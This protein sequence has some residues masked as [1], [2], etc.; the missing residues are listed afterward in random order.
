MLRKAVQQQCQAGTPRSFYT[1]TNGYPL[2]NEHF[3][4]E[5]EW[6]ITWRIWRWCAKER[7]FSVA[8][9]QITHGYLVGFS[10]SRGRHGREWPWRTGQAGGPMSRCRF[11]LLGSPINK[12]IQSWADSS[13]VDLMAL[14]SL[15]HLMAQWVKK[16]E[17][18][19]GQVNN[20][21]HQR[22]PR[23]GCVFCS[24]RAVSPQLKALECGRDFK[25]RHLKLGNRRIERNMLW[26]DFQ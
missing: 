23:I 14:W 22:C 18:L 13:G 15:W 4:I 16:S 8:N 25:R 3:A 10:K 21:C 9:C 11:K 12:Q 2:V 1:R 20:S 5:N 24:A 26:H 17:L 7:P 6:D 19:E